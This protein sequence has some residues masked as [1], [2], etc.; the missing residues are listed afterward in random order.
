MPPRHSFHRSFQLSHVARFS[1][2]HSVRQFRSI[3]KAAHLHGVSRSRQSAGIVSR[4]RLSASFHFFS[5]RCIISVAHIVSSHGRLC[6][7]GQKSHKTSFF[8]KKRKDFF[9]VKKRSYF[10]K[11]LLREGI[12]ALV[13]CLVSSAPPGRRFSFAV[14]HS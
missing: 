1:S 6:P 11:F 13:V 5:F 9:C 8:H 14:S 4:S 3:F 12:A 10:V 7:R 2:R